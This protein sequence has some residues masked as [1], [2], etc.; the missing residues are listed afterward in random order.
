MRIIS[1]T[2]HVQGMYTLLYISS[3]R[4]AIAYY[5]CVGLPEPQWN[6]IHSFHAFFVHGSIHRFK[7]T[8]NM[9]QYPCPCFMKIDLEQSVDKLS[10]LKEN[11]SGIESPEYID[12]LP[13]QEL[14]CCLCLLDSILLSIEQEQYTCTVTELIRLYQWRKRIATHFL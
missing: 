9:N 12:T 11:Y 13:R 1:E 3:R 8:N 6:N 14:L 10:F 2:L 4:G 7:H 5:S